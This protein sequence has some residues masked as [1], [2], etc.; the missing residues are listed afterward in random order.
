MRTS[1]L[2]RNSGPPTDG[3]RASTVK[4]QDNRLFHIPL[5]GFPL[6][7]PLIQNQTVLA[8]TGNRGADHAVP[9]CLYLPPHLSTTP[10]IG[11]GSHRGIRYSPKEYLCATA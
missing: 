11:H 3:R 1:E 4:I 6:D 10:V 9:S 8:R 5:R 2:N 7:K